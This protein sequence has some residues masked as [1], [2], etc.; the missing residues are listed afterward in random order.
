M[1]ALNRRKSA[2]SAGAH[3]DAARCHQS[4]DV[5][6]LHIRGTSP[7]MIRS[8]TPDRQ[9]QAHGKSRWRDAV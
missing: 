9:M 7:H 8:H 6:E 2:T 5:R 4:D 1:E 3:L